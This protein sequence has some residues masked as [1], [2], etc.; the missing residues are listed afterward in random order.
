MAARRICIIIA[1]PEYP[2][3]RPPCPHTHVR[4]IRIG[5]TPG[6]YNANIRAE[7]ISADKPLFLRFCY[8]HCTS[9]V[10]PPPP[11]PPTPLSNFNRETP[12]GI[13]AAKPRVAD[14]SNA[15]AY[16]YNPLVTLSKIRFKRFVCECVP[17]CVNLF[18]NNNKNV[19]QDG[20]WRATPYYYKI[21]CHDDKFLWQ[22]T[23]YVNYCHHTQ[24]LSTV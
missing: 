24:V 9:T 8:A 11:P 17:E 12:K 6:F 14:K 15:Y 4:P 16:Y 22:M 18:L 13:I 5:H 20:D 23:S 7:L 2:N 3:S 21:I 19:T 1:H 10:Q